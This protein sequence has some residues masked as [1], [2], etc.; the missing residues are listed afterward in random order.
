MDS[1]Y[2]LR[3]TCRQCEGIL[4]HYFDTPYRL[5]RDCHRIVESLQDHK[6]NSEATANEQD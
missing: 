4:E 3:I 6:C 2:H 1:Q 5:M